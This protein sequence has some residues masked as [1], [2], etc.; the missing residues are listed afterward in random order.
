VVE[1]AGMTGMLPVVAGSAVEG[2][3]FAGADIPVRA[4]VPMTPP[5]TP[6]RRTQ[7]GLCEARRRRR[8]CE[9]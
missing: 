9:V 8:I 7:L 1:R 2:S 4:S 6:A 5:A 3:A